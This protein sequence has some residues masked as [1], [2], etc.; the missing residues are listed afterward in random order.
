M[1]YHGALAGSEVVSIASAYIRMREVWVI[2][3]VYTD[4]RYRSRGYGKTAVSSV[5]EAALSAGAAAMLHVAEGN[6]AAVRLYRRLGYRVVRHRPWV[7]CR[8]QQAP[9]ERG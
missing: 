2:G 6:T 1:R 3:G 7:F 8:P 4:P 5:T 9:E